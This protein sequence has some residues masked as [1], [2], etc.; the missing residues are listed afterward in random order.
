MQPVAGLPPPVEAL[1]AWHPFFALLGSAS[2][3]MVGLLFVAVSVGT[4]VFS[5]DRPAPLRVFLSA[6]VVH[7]ASVLVA[8]LVMTAPVLDWPLLGLMIL[9][10]GGFGLIYS[11]IA[12]R[13]TVRDGMVARIDLEDRTWYIALP[14]LSYLCESA[15]GIALAMHFRPAVTSLALSIG[16]LLVIAIHNAWDITIWTTMKKRE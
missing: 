6:S 2:A 14:I 8:C 12:L 3:T 10:C 9:G 7:F 16:A 5:V 13:D 15:S 1:D 11:S 4:G